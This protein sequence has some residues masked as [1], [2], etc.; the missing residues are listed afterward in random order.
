MTLRF[1]GSRSELLLSFGQVLALA[2]LGP[3][4]RAAVFAGGGVL[5]GLEV[6]AEH[7]VALG[8][9]AVLRVFDCEVDLAFFE[10]LADNGADVGDGWLLGGMAAWG[11][12]F[13]WYVGADGM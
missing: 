13:G 5:E 10:V 11:G 7:G 1:R 9:G 8:V 3:G 4:D 2:L 6:G 12:G